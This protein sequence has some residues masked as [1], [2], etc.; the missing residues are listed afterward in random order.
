MPSLEKCYR[1]SIELWSISIRTNL[2]VLVDSTTRTRSTKIHIEIHHI[3][4]L[5]S[6]DQ[7][8]P[9]VCPLDKLWDPF[10]GHQLMLSLISRAL[11]IRLQFRADQL[12]PSSQRIF[13]C[14]VM[15]ELSEFLSSLLQTYLKR[16]R[17]QS[18]RFRLLP[19][20]SQLKCDRAD[21]TI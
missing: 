8:L 18:G 15:F 16:R 6:M 1:S 14:D 9:Q 3:A 21:A 17:G 10:L 2:N 19:V 11:G 13:D 7:T 5:F 4:W 12:V 20:I